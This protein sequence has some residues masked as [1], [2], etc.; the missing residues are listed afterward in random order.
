MWRPLV[1]FFVAH[2]EATRMSLAEF[3]QGTQLKYG[4]GADPEVFTVIAHVKGEIP[5]P[6]INS[7]S[8]EV[9]DHDSPDHTKEFIA[10]LIDP[11]QLKVT[12]NYRATDA[13]QKVLIGKAQSR[14]IG[15]WQIVM[16]DT[17]ASVWAFTAFVMGFQAKGAVDNVYEADVT[18]QVTGTVTPPA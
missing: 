15:N 11:G 6:Q 5:F 17:G 18:F 14:A 4:D 8:K 10:T 13:T 2:K 16:V 12:L 1:A 3:A 7:D 9:T